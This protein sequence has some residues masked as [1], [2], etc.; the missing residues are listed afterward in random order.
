MYKILPI[1]IIVF[2]L[3]ISTLSHARLEFNPFINLAEEYNDNIFL[4]PSDDE[5]SDWI[6]TIEPGFTLEYDS[7]TLEATLDYSMIFRLYSSNSN[8]DETSLK[9]VSRAHADLTL[10]PDNNFNLNAD[11][12][13]SRVIMD[14]RERSSDENDFINKATLY[15]YTI[16]PSYNLR[17]GS[18]LN[19]SLDY[20]F[21]QSIYEDIEDTDENPYDANDYIQHRA[22]TRLTKRI[23]GRTDIYISYA[24]TNFDEDRHESDVEN[25]DYSRHDVMA[26]FNYPLGSRLVLRAMGGMNW[27]DYD[28]ESLDDPDGAIWNVGIDYSFLETMQATLEYN[29]DFINSVSR[30][31]S[32][33]QEARFSLT[34][35][36]RLTITSELY[37]SKAKYE[38]DNSEDR[39]AGGRIIFTLPLGQRF[40]L[41]LNTD[42]AHYKYEYSEPGQEDED[43]DRY[44]VGASIN[45]NF[46]HLTASLSYNYRRNNSDAADNENDYTNNIA[47][48]ELGWEF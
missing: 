33:H 21:E 42:Y 27:I 24:Y 26:G 38:E 8:E 6:T 7:H 46:N 11:G 28:D 29:K 47:M 44:A 4:D 1:L 34:Y 20:F 30:G 19:L 39:A 32:D 14:D 25:E 18:S 23:F 3:L 41:G 22:E 10:F 48:L 12:D 13:I 31:L 17:L 5:E 9:D 16:N 43:V 2:M 45:Y 37:A 36:R 40:D 35:S 15:H